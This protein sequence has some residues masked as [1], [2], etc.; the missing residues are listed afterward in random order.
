MPFGNRPA[1][2]Y[3]SN[4]PTILFHFLTNVVE[5]YAAQ[6]VAPPLSVAAQDQ[7]NLPVVIGGLV[8]LLLIVLVLFWR[9]SRGP[10]STPTERPAVPSGQ[11]AQIVVPPPP[12]LLAI[13]LEFTAESGPPIRFTL[14]KP[15]LT[16]G[17]AADN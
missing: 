7:I 13:S 16:I 17:R 12:S 6:S 10:R 5:H 3:N 8:L 11:P 15:T 2:S 14:D 1:R 9:M 4:V